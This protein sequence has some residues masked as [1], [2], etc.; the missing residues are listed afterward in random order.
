MKSRRYI[1]ENIVIVRI[2]EGLGNQLFQYAYARALSEKGLDVRLDM[3]K[4]YDE[5]FPKIRSHDRRQNSIQNFNL[6]L[7]EIDVE[8]YGKYKYIKREC[9][10]DKVIFHLAVRGLWN[11]KFYEEVVSQYS[12]KSACIRGNYYVKGWFQEE[13][14]FQHIR[15]ELL[16]ELTPKKKIRISRELRREI[17]YEE[18]V[19]LHVRRGDYVRTRN[20]LNLSYYKNAIAYIKEHCQNPHILFFSDDLSWVRKNFGKEENYIYVNEDGRL[21][22]YEE[23]LVMSKCK[24]N[25][26]SNSTF[27]WWGA[28]LN[29]NSEKIVIAP[30]NCWLP[31]QKNMILL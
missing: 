30:R 28:W 26:I 21:K 25:I 9:L 15:Q 17:D 19:A 6:A 4:T 24:S 18:S 7:P 12:R 16:K 31:R 29:R 3:D 11:Y 8:K 22:D 14:Y 13:R 27:S 10:K 23:L 20:A 1:E 5:V 2:W